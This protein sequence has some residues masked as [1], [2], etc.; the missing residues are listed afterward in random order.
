MNKIFIALL[1]G[2]ATLAA[3]LAVAN[4]AEAI[5]LATLPTQNFAFC[6]Q[7]STQVVLSSQVSTE[8]GIVIAD[9]GNAATNSN[10]KV[11]IAANNKYKNGA[12]G[13]WTSNMGAFTLP[14]SCYNVATMN[15]YTA[16]NGST[17]WVCALTSG[18]AS[19][20]GAVF[21]GLVSQETTT[22]TIA[23]GTTIAGVSVTLNSAPV[24]NCAY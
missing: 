10:G 3:P 22:T 14:A 4:A 6:T 11:V 15:K 2:I 7:S 17:S 21:S 19:G 20:A 1:S 12:G 5:V 18:A 23:S 24:I 8:V 9:V 13:E 16:P